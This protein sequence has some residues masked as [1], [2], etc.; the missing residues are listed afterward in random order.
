M[1]NYLSSPSSWCLSWSWPTTTC[2]AAGRRPAWSWPRPGSNM[3]T[4]GW[5]WG[6]QGWQG[7]RRRAG[8][9]ITRWPGNSS[10]NCALSSSSFYCLDSCDFCVPSLVHNVPCPFFMVLLLFFT[11]MVFLLFLLYTVHHPIAH[12]L[13][14][15]HLTLHPLHAQPLTAH[16][17]S[18]HPLVFYMLPICFSTSYFILLFLLFPY[19]LFF[20]L[21]SLWH[22]SLF[23][24]YIS[25]CKKSL[26]ARLSLNIVWLLAYRWG[27]GGDV[28]I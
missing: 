14:V 22:G 17:L 23:F 21:L 9:D 18:A 26:C 13:T 20:I 12:P 16:S 15:H 1:S 10:P 8:S 4:R 2:G 5:S 6:G 3:R 11:P 28:H 25:E 19:L 24:I 27:K 7:C